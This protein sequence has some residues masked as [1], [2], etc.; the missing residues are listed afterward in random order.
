MEI[1]TAD[2]ARLRGR[3]HELNPI[4]NIAPAITVATAE[5]NQEAFGYP[6][7]QLTVSD[8]TGWE[9]VRVRQ[10]VWIGTAPGQADV[11][12]GVVRRPP[13]STL[14]YIDA[15]DLGST[16]H[17]RAI[18]QPLMDGMF[19]TII[20]YRP[21]WAHYSAIRNKKFFKDFDRQYAGEGANPAPIIRLGRHRSA[22]RDPITGEASFHFSA[23]VFCWGNKTPVLYEWHTDGGTIDGPDDES[24]ID[25]TFDT[26][27]FYEVSLRVRDSGN[28]SATAYRYVWV[29]HED[30]THEHAPF[31]WR[32]PVVIENDHQD[33]KG[34]KIEFGILAN[35]LP[36]NTLFP[37]QAV[38]M[39]E[40]PTFAGEALE[41]ADAVVHHYFGYSTDK[42]I[43]TSYRRKY[44]LLPTEGPFI[45]ADR[46]GTTT[47]Q[48]TERKSPKDWQEVTIHLSNPVG[49]A[50]Y[51]ATYHA[52]YL[53]A[54]HDFRFDPAIM[55]LR[56]RSFVFQATEIG[57]QYE[58][59]AEMIPGFIGAR[60]DGTIRMLQNPVYQTNPFRAFM[61]ERWRWLPGDIVGELI[62]PFTFISQTSKVSGYAYSYH[63]GA[64]STPY[65]S[66]APGHVGVQAGTHSRMTPFTV[67]R[68][69][70]QARVNEITGH[71][72]AEENNPTPLFTIIADR[73]LDVHEPIDV[74]RWSY[75]DIPAEFDP[76]GG[77][78]GNISSPNGYAGRAFP[79]RI[80]R[81]W[82][83]EGAPRK[84]VRTDFQPETFGQPGITIPITRGAASG[85]WG[86]WWGGTD[87]SWYIGGPGSGGGSGG[88]GGYTANPPAFPFRSPVMLAANDRGR[89][90]RTFTFDATA[91]RWQRLTAGFVGQVR[92]ISIDV[93]S[94]YFTEG[95]GNLGVF[96]ITDNVDSL[97][98]TLRVYYCPNILR[99]DPRWSAR[100]TFTPLAGYNKRARIIVSPTQSGFVMVVYR[101]HSGIFA[102]RSTTNGSGWLT[103]VQVGDD[104]DTQHQDD[105]IGAAIYGQ[106]QVVS[107][108]D[109]LPVDGRV[110][111]AVWTA[112]TPSASF[113]KV[114][115]VPTNYEV[116]SGT[117]S[118]ISATEGFV[119]L[120]NKSADPA[121][122]TPIDVV[123][124]GTGGYPSYEL[125]ALTSVNVVGGSPAGNPPPTASAITNLATTALACAAEVTVDLEGP[126][127]V[128]TIYF[129]R[130][131]QYGGELIEARVRSIVTAFD[132]FGQPVGSFTVEDCTVPNTG[133]T[134]I[135]D[136]WEWLNREVTAAQL[137]ISDYVRKITVRCILTWQ[138]DPGVGFAQVHIDNIDI[139]AKR[140]DD[141]PGRRLYRFSPTGAFWTDI[142]PPT[143]HLPVH[144]YGIGAVSAANLTTLAQSEAGYTFML[145]RASSVWQNRGQTNLLG[146]KRRDNIIIVFGYGQIGVGLTG[147]PPLYPRAGDWMDAVGPIGLIEVVAGVIEDVD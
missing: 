82:S 93:H 26:T 83:S 101:D 32:Y 85:F 64:E 30:P 38:L 141:E 89:L 46:I 37:G 94:Q 45:R 125:G 56:R 53:L 1:S 25:I 116:F 92:D 19:I 52:P 109:G 11:A 36:P 67:T 39:E 99:D 127:I 2:Q 128:D 100:G 8:T 70:G 12:Y 145:Q 68:Q 90:A 139:R 121:T 102:I 24:E 10:M 119:P 132:E 129:D 96:I 79:V 76:E 35:E 138:S 74:D 110:K 122:L 49:A 47:Q 43:E 118:L 72:L 41:D 29:N 7:A 120:I 59:L 18:T 86:G 134:D 105:Y 57:A 126:C 142:S 144:S 22:F 147:G 130:M 146:I 20:K 13:T 98:S 143:P 34:R 50:W 108:P 28:A 107:A 106:R 71:R 97:D 31:S 33:V 63:G 112:D 137:G 87:A 9:N 55:S 16:G 48:I 62:Y 6:V 60:S 5:I 73:N 51:I 115:D 133:F 95:S 123:T 15:K 4:I 113:T 61:P 117:L 111:Y 27:G 3:S 131:F 65:E 88:D 23:D 136:G 124:F 44:L 40:N 14:L 81:A 114:P 54:A 84:Q 78:W 140:A 135:C 66:L 75:F 77:G 42:Q 58:A 17:P 103:A 21:P 80:N 91:V 104:G 69:Q